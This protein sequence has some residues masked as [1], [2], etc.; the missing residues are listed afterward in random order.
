M[1]VR[2]H[3]LVKNRRCVGF[4]WRQQKPDKSEVFQQNNMVVPRVAIGNRNSAE[5]LWYPWDFL[6]MRR[7]QRLR[8]NEHGEPLFNEA[9]GV[10]KKLRIAIDQ[11]LVYRAQIQPDR[12][13]V[14]V[15][16][17]DQP[18]AD[19]YRTIQ[20]WKQML[21]SRMSFGNGTNPAQLEL[22]TD[23]KVYYDPWALDTVLFLAQ[24]SNFKHTIEKLAGTAT[25]PDVFDIELL[26]N[27][28]YSVMGMPQSW[29][30]IK[31]GADGGGGQAPASGKA[32]LAQ[33][34]RFLRKVKS[35]RRPIIDAYTWLAYFHLLLTGKN[36]AEYNV[37]AR[38]ADV[39]SLEDQMRL[40]LLTAQV[41]LVGKVTES[42]KALSVPDHVIV[43]L[44]FKR[45][46]RLP[47]DFVN[48]VVTALPPEKSNMQES[49]GVM[50]GPAMRLIESV[51]AKN[52]QAIKKI[53]E[54]SDILKISRSG[55]TSTNTGARIFES[56]RQHPQRGMASLVEPNDIVVGSY[57]QIKNLTE[58]L[59]KAAN[60]APA[61]EQTATRRWGPV[62]S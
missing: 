26:M 2:R 1:D 32:L 24:P 31:S 37:E 52:P 34:M 33:D 30:G 57:D 45:Y 9:Q 17:K 25:V 10:Y 53:Q 27:L 36:P 8:M 4:K 22:P 46:M 48:A 7:M 5:D 44:L 16:V 61:A 59:M 29:F 28:F 56:F 58:G 11:M 39:G 23:F 55:Y 18:P 49:T 50:I 19:Q 60:T 41:D 21:R 20:R 51:A 35:I 42:F 13:V 15:D 40:E 47:D 43:E 6:H 38:M 12:F 3:W 62:K 14:N 54:L